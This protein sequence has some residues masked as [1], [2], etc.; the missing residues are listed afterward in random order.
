[1][2]VLTKKRCPR[3]GRRPART[4]PYLEGL[5]SRCLLSA[6][7]TLSPDA[8]FHETLDAALDL[9]ALAVGARLTASGAI[10]AG[11]EGAADVTWYK[12]SLSNTAEVRLA[13]QPGAG[14]PH[15]DAALSLYNDA[16][17][18]LDPYTF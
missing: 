3:R 6:P 8:L 4:R 11:P 2:T 12:F 18:T 14:G 10:G 5:E 16:P 7:G 13:I 17:P 1:M 9:R 15:L